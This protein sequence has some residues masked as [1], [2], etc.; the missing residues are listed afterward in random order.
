MHKQVA[1]RVILAVSCLAVLSALLS[2]QIPLPDNPMTLRRGVDANAGLVSVTDQATK[3]S[4]PR[5]YAHYTAKD[6]RKLIDSVW[7]P[8]LPTRNF[9][10][11]TASGTTSTSTL[12]V[13]R[14]SAS[15]GTR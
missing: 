3:P 5:G 14:I 11:L 8:G 13:S 4:A 15:T 7:G 10:S 12:G 9:R 6:W 2:A 1:L